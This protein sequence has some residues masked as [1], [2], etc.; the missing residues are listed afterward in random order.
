MA[1]RTITAFFKEEDDVRDAA[2]QLKALAARQISLDT[3]PEDDHSRSFGLFPFFA[4]G[5][6][7]SANTINTSAGP[8]SGIFPLYVEDSDDQLKQMLTF[9]ID[10]DKLEDALRIIENERGVANEKQPLPI[11]KN[12]YVHFDMDKADQDDLEALAM[13][14]QADE[15]Q[16]R[17]EYEGENR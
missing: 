9:T 10:D 11:Q 4:S 13:A 17:A 15:R 7:N 12:E 1:E 16:Q 14:R 6:T 5:Q 2:I 8:L 3:I